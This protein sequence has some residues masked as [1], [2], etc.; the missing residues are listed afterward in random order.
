MLAD[1]IKRLLEVC[2]RAYRFVTLVPANHAGSYLVKGAFP[3]CAIQVQKR[4]NHSI[5]LRTQ[6]LSLRTSFPLVQN[7]RPGPSA[8]R[9]VSSASGTCSTLRCRAIR[10]VEMTQAEGKR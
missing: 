7:I 5:V 3:R 9:I 4:F 8:R 1:G 6:T 2:S 10:G